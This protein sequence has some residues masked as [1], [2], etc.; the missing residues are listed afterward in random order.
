MRHVPPIRAALL[1]SLSALLSAC[2]SLPTLPGLGSK[3]EAQASRPP[4]EAPRPDWAPAQAPDLP[5]FGAV[6]AP[7][8]VPGAPLATPAPG[9][10]AAA[11][12][13]SNAATAK[14]YRQDAAR[15]LYAQNGHRIYPGPM[16]PMLYAVGVL[17][18]DIDSQGQVTQLRW[19]RAP[20]HAPEVME[21]IERTVRQ[22]APYPIPARLG[23]VTYTDIWLWHESGR[24]QL[25]TLTEGQE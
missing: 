3:A 7:S 4:A 23:R 11:P 5:T 10:R 21:E 25:D 9:Q 2:N 17:E 20:S 1:A 18:T 12:S 19:K 14:Q 22:A 13:Y 24:F 16:P 15:H 8:F 6:P